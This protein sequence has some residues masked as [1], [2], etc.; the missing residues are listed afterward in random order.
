MADDPEDRTYYRTRIVLQTET[1]S[2][3]ALT[4]DIRFGGGAQRGR[5]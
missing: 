2:Q 3:L 4:V 5:G 1:G